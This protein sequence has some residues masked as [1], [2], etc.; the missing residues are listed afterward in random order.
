MD[1]VNFVWLCGLLQNF[2]QSLG[3]DSQQLGMHAGIYRKDSVGVWVKQKSK[4]PIWK[5]NYHENSR[6]TNLKKHILKVLKPLRYTA[7]RYLQPH[8]GNGVF[9]NV[10]FSAGQH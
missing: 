7:R 6:E 10:Y 2:S 4:L 5:Y 1:Y 9:G 8:Y 3:T